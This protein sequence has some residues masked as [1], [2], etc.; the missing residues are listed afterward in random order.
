MEKGIRVLQLLER[1]RHIESELNR[2][3]AEYS[4]LYKEFDG[5]DF[6]NQGKF[7][8]VLDDLILH[9]THELASEIGFGRARLDQLISLINFRKKYKNLSEEELTRL[10]DD[11]GIVVMERNRMKGLDPREVQTE[12]N[13]RFKNTG[14]MK[15]KRKIGL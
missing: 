11:K 13:Q 15:I 1:L 8:G 9:L 6:E 12:W 3:D 7:A 4:G 14:Y 2:L 5:A 10:I